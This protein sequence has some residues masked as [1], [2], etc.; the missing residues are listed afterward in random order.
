MER[1]VIR[2]YEVVILT[3]EE[4]VLVD[5]GIALAKELKC[6]FIETSAMLS[7]NSDRDH[8]TQETCSQLDSPSKCSYN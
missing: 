1:A 4:A 3:S 8:P 6:H 2:I 7:I 5:N